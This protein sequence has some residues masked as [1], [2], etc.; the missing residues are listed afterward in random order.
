MPMAEEPLEHLLELRLP[1]RIAR[2]A[3]RTASSSLIPTPAQPPWQRLYFFPDPQ[4]QGSLR[5]IFGISRT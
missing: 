5:P 1:A 3:A 2:I 4:G